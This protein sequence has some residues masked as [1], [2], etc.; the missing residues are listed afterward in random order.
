MIMVGRCGGVA[1]VGPYVIDL[2]TG[3]VTGGPGEGMVNHY[4]RETTEL[5]TH[6]FAP[7]SCENCAEIAEIVARSI[8]EHR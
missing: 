1:S 6:E 4:D 7:D 2:S 5:E 3:V 8:A